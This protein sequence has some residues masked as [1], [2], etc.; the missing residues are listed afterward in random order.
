MHAA[1]IVADHAAE[2]ATVVGCGIGREGEVVLLGCG[3]QSVEDNS[4]LDAGDAAVGVDLENGRHV[5]R[6]VE[7]DG[8]VTALSGERG[9][10]AARKQRSVVV[11]AQGN[12]GENV[13]FIAG[14]YDA[15]RHL[16]IIGAVGC[17][18]GATA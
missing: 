13:F 9:A 15:D 6:E 10:S 1:G 7:D 14:N 3:A 17:I 12:G 18:E 2:R 8:G 5:F 11:A 16:A 4:G